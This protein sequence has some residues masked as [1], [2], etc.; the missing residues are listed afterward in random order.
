MKKLLI[1]IALFISLIQSGSAS[2]AYYVGG[3]A[4]QNKLGYK[5]VSGFILSDGSTYPIKSSN[6]YDTS[7]TGYGIFAGKSF[8]R[9]DIELGYNHLSSDKSN[10]NTGLILLPSSAI[11]TKSEVKLDM[12]S[13]DFKPTT[14][15]G[16]I[17]NLRIMPIFGLTYAKAN[18][19]EHYSA[20]GTQFSSISETQN[21]L[22]FDLGV[23]L[24]YQITDSFFVRTQAKYTRLDMK[25][26][27]TLGVAGLN[28]V[29]T[30]SVGAGY[31]F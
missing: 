28:Y 6:Y 2:E 4:T 15:V 13:L 27:K 20:N 12:L 21:K 3:E 10:N 24:K 19:K 9:L 11:T 22:G 8:E 26:N 30:A 18:F 5:N 1:S 29:A 23:G 14:T 25:T 31:S 16:N 7:S 17:K